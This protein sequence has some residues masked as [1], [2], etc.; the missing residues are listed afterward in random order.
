MSIYKLC[1]MPQ[2]RFLP[3]DQNEHGKK[4]HAMLAILATIAT[5]Y[6]PCYGG[7]VGRLWTPGCFHDGAASELQLWKTF[8]QRRNQHRV[9]LLRAA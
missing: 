9:R 8:E 1:G 5:V 7:L 4:G 2:L 3:P 6:S